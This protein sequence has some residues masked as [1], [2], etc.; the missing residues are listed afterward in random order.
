MFNLKQAQGE[1][2]FSFLIP[3]FAAG[4]ARCG[5]PDCFRAQLLVRFPESAFCIGSVIL[6][7]GPRK[8][9]ASRRPP[10]VF[11]FNLGQMQP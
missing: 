6:A 9:F 8:S 4:C 7:G 10:A 3:G 1:N 11:R 2:R 5:A